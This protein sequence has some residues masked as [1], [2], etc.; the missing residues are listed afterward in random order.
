VADG[1]DWAALIDR[2]LRPFRTEEAA[3]RVLLVVAAVFG[4]IIAIVLVAK[5]L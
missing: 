1:R 4:A 3:F 5:A 2:L